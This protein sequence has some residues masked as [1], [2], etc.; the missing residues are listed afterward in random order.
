MDNINGTI[1]E[2][3]ERIDNYNC[4]INSIR[5]NIKECNKKIKRLER[6]QN[7]L[8]SLNL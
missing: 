4:E 6:I 8:E 7:E 5:E 1:R 2:L 3:N